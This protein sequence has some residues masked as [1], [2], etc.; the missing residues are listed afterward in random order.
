MIHRL[1][2]SFVF[3]STNFFCF[4]LLNVRPHSDFCLHCCCQF[5]NNTWKVQQNMSFNRKLKPREAVKRGQS[6]WPLETFWIINC[7]KLHMMPEFKIMIWKTF[8]LWLWKFNLFDLLLEPFNLAT[9]PGVHGQKSQSVCSLLIGS[10]SGSGRC[11]VVWHIACRGWGINN[12]LFSW[13]RP[14]ATAVSI[15]AHSTRASQAHFGKMWVWM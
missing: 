6:M 2:S 7:T 11:C 14:W 1:H 10:C 12:P 3:S 9:P 15:A 4:E 13:T 5:S 8:I